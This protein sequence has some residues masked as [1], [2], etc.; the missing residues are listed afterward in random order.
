[1][2]KQPEYR[3]S[4]KSTF[5][6][7]TTQDDVL[8]VASNL[9]G[10]PATSS[11]RPHGGKNALQ[12]VRCTCSYRSQQGA[13]GTAAQC[14]QVRPLDR[15]HPRCARNARVFLMALISTLPAFNGDSRTARR[16]TR[17]YPRPQRAR[18]PIAPISV[19]HADVDFTRR[20]HAPHW[21]YQIAVYPP[22]RNREN[23]SWW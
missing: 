9:R 15:P 23:P 2:I 17:L 19:L 14:R 18:I 22:H 1:M 12:A 3:R 10:P 20:G 8:E 16:R 6:G 11:R 7:G 4:Q 21:R 13:R 5:G